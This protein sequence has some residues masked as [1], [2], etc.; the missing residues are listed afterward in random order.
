M[1]LFYQ[2]EGKEIALVQI[3]EGPDPMYFVIILFKT[4]DLH[5]VSK[6][7]VL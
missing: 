7:G 3:I 5:D 4:S 2:L 1:D 6:V